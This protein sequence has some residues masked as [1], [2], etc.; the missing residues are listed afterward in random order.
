MRIKGFIN[1]FLV[2]VIIFSFYCSVC[3]EDVVLK[4]FHAGSLSVPFKK[5]E[6]VFEN[7]YPWIDVR[8]ESS[9]S[10]MAVRKVIDIHKECD[11]V[12][13]ADYSLIPSMMF[14]KYADHVKLFARNELVLCYTKNSRYSKSIS[15]RNW[16]KILMKDDVKW[17]FSNPNLDPCGYR[18]V[19]CIMLSE[20]YYKKPITKMLLKKYLPFN[21]IR[22][23]D[24][25]IAEIPG[26]FTPK[27]GKIFI[28]PKE[29]DLLGLLE[30][31]VID[32]AI[33]YLSVA[34]QHQLK[35]LRFPS[36]INLGHLE[37]KTYYSKVVVVLGNGRMIKG[38][39][40]VYG[41]A[42]L[43][44]SLHPKEAKLFEEFVTGKTGANIIRSFFQI[45]I[46]PVKI[47]K[48][49]E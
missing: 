35:F 22:K 20:Y 42:M 40:I 7:K 5:M 48:I 47:I 12:A 18:A 1:V 26:S 8:R 38:K 41:I 49:D 36:E 2:C 17:G 23:D 33:E 46:Y 11:V 13:V 10:V 3:A 14:P 31:G 24:L 37:L 30:S 28:R 39:P 34:K 16:Y 6:E 45:P 25:I 4:V 32:Y 19:M 29:V 43:K 27:G 44:N 15:N 21:F 9:G